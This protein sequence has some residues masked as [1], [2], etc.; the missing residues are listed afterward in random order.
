MPSVD[1]M[2][3]SQWLKAYD[4]D[5]DVVARVERVAV[6]QVGPEREDRWIV[7]FQGQTK[8]LLL[9]KTNAK[10]LGQ[11]YGLSEAWIGKAIVLFETQVDAFGE[12][13]DVIRMR[14]PTEDDLQNVVPTQVA[15]Q[16]PDGEPAAEL[17]PE[18]ES[19]PAQAETA[20]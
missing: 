4:I 12:T 8:G 7:Y 6:E 13:H 9:N 19:E 1:E 20:F 5:G 15:E 18:A 2:F 14:A 10:V 11:L 3:P 17:F 16:Y